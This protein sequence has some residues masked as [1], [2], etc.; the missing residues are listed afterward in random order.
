[1]TQ[2]SLKACLKRWG[3]RA[4]KAMNSE[5]KQL[6]LQDTFKPRH[7]HDLTRKQK[8]KVLESHMFRKENRSDKIKGRTV[9]GG[10]K[11]RNFISK[12]DASSP[13]VVTE[14]V[15]VTCIVEA[16]EERYVAVVDIPNAF[17]QTKVESVNN[18][19]TIQVCG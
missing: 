2:L 4:K 9:A 5:T 13:T 12:E 19:A 15:L 7:F 8:A 18:M 14:S 11:Q 10:N 6:H 17:I 3:P 1:M 16:Q